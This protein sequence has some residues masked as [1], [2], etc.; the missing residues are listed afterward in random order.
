MI[1]QVHRD[2]VCELEEMGYCTKGFMALY[3][4]LLAGSFY[5]RDEDYLYSNVFNLLK[6][7]ERDSPYNII[8]KEFRRFYRDNPD[9][10][11]EIRNKIEQHILDD[12]D[13]LQEG[14]EADEVPYD[15][16]SMLK[17]FYKICS[18]HF[19][20][21]YDKVVPD[22]FYLDATNGYLDIVEATKSHRI[23]L[24][25]LGVYGVMWDEF[26]DTK[27]SMRLYDVILPEK[28]TFEHWLD[29]CYFVEMDAITSKKEYYET[30]EEFRK[31]MENG[32]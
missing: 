26:E 10:V 21:Y 2:Y 16:D 17:Y 9:K 1:S 32:S 25:K 23:D 14:E 13:D 30:V 22:G 12:I 5:I 31:E 19:T 27:Y 4:F 11:K 15:A 8:K 20:T 18:W 24:G 3:R 7:S 29:V 28:I 6:S